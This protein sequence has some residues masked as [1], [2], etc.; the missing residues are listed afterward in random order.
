MPPSFFV[1]E[2]QCGEMRDVS[3]MRQWSAVCITEP[4]TDRLVN[5]LI[6]VLLLLLQL[7]VGVSLPVCVSAAVY[8][9]VHQRHRRYHDVISRLRSRPQRWL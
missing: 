7:P 8:H 6:A 1:G 2:Q 5:V 4:L 9:S 3:I